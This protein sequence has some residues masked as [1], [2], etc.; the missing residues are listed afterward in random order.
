MLGV[1]QHQ[2]PVGYDIFGL[3]SYQFASSST[4]KAVN[5]HVSEQSKTTTGR[6]AYSTMI[7]TAKRQ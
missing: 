5:M 2:H 1:A 4:V 7:N 6:P 3:K